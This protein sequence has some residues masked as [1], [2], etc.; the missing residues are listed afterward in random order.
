MTYTK[1]EI[2]ELREALH[3]FHPMSGIEKLVKE[4]GTGLVKGAYVEKAK[5]NWDALAYKDTHNGADIMTGAV[6]G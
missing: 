1:A 5:E 4:D 3:A 6:A 2:R